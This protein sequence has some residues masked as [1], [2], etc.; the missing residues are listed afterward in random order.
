MLQGLS[1][2]EIAERIEAGAIPVA[3]TARVLADVAAGLDGAHAKG[4]VHRDL[5]PGNILYGED[6]DRPIVTD[7]RAGCSPG[8]ASR[9]GER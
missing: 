8:D 7:S 3:E 9:S 5:K 4:I 1:T 2:G 6:P